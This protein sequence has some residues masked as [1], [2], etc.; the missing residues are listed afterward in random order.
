MDRLKLVPG[1][2]NSLSSSLT[3]TQSA[4]EHWAPGGSNIFVWIANLDG[5]VIYDSSGLNWST[6]AQLIQGA[7]KQNGQPMRK[8]DDVVIVESVFTVK[9]KKY[10]NPYFS[11]N[12]QTQLWPGYK[13]KDGSETKISDFFDPAYL[14]NGTGVG[15]SP[16]KTFRTRFGLAAR[17]IITNKYN[18]FAEGERIKTDAGM[19]WVTYLEQKFW[20][21]IHIR[22]NLQLF[23]SFKDIRAGNILWDTKLEASITKYI[24]VNLQTFLVVD[25]NISP[26]SQFKEVLSIGVKYTFI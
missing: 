23:A 19:Q 25:A 5:S 14:T 3:V 1:W 10:L 4:H 8:S 12:I 20:D 17:T 18:S 16:T 6:D 7:S 26:Y 2:N 24:I 15:Y 21:K 9:E 11:L 22:S 13:Y